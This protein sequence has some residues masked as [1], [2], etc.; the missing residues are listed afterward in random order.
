MI[1]RPR[2]R[3]W[4]LFYIW[5]GS[6]LYSIRWALLT[7]VA[8]ATAISVIHGTL[9]SIKVT[10]TTIPFSLIGLALAIFLGFRNS[11]CYDRF[12][13]GRKLWGSLVIETRNLTRQVL[14]YVVS[15]AHAGDA[16]TRAEQDAQVRRI[17]AFTH[18]LR[19]HLRDS[20]PDDDLRSHLSAED[21]AECLRSVNRPDW[22]LRRMGRQVAA[23]NR[24]NRVQ[25][26]MALA[27]DNTLDRMGSVVGGCERIR[28]TPI[29]F[30]YTLMLHRTA[31]LYCW[32]LPFGLI[33]SIGF[34]TPIVV[35]IVSYTI[36]GLDALGDEIEEPFGTDPNDL[37]LTS[38]CTSIERT[39]RDA[40]GDT[41]LPAA[42]EPVD[43]LL[44]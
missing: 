7:N 24:Q 16:G 20:A 5:H 26:Q 9:F 38:L 34:M 32:L 19:H 42:P 3:G 4:Q 29:P 25:D 18:A 41:D 14:A 12:W 36:F 33:D 13:E 21:H 28:S 2:P 30:A 10:L 35:T 1:V 8:L 11:S 23:W 15:S 17:V 43:H 40:L 44:Q 31:N 27:M 37:P 6:I 22:L 39:L